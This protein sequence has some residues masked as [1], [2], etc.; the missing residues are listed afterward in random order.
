VARTSVMLWKLEVS[1]SPV[2]SMVETREL[3]PHPK[4][5]APSVWG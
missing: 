2:L 3:G 1:P 5:A 4:K